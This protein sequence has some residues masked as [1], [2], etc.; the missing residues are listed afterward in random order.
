MY[1]CW[2]CSR[3][4]RLRCPMLSL[5]TPAPLPAGSSAP[6][7]AA[8]R[9]SNCCLD[10]TRLLLLPYLLQSWRVCAASKHGIKAAVVNG[11]RSIQGI[12]PSAACS[13][14]MPQ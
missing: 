11:D 13:Q 10:P 5:L 7:A 14:M 8:S 9:P 6:H 3:G 12:S 1:G 2:A 4:K